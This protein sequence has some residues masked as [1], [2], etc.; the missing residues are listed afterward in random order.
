MKFKLVKLLAFSLVLI[1]GISLFAGCVPIQQT[2]TPTTTAPL[3]TEPEGPAEITVFLRERWAGVPFDGEIIK[4]VQEKTNTKWHI[5]VG[6][7]LDAQ[8][9]TLF[10]AR[11]Y[12]DIITFGGEELYLQSLIKDGILLPLDEHLDK[13]PNLYEKK[14]GIW[15]KLKAGD[16]KVYHVP[17][18][19]EANGGVDVLMSYRKDWLDKF[20]FEIPETIEEYITVADAFSNQD[21]DG[22]NI[23]DTFAIGARQGSLGRFGDFIFAAHGVLPYFWIEEDDGSLVYGSVHPNMREALKVAA[24]LFEIGAID[25]EFIT[26]SSSTYNA[27]LTS[28]VYGACAIFRT[29]FDPTNATLYIPFKEKVPNGEWVF[30][31]IPK[32]A[33]YREDINLRATSPRGW[34]R[35]GI[36]AKSKEVDACLRVL[37]WMN[38]DEGIMYSQYGVEG[39]HYEFKDGVVKKLVDEETSRAL[40]IYEL[41]IG[42]EVLPLDYTPE[43][44]AST[45]FCKSR[46]SFSAADGLIVEEATLYELD[47]EEY[48]NSQIIRIIF[49]EVPVDEG[50]D[51]MVSEFYRRGGQELTDAYNRAKKAK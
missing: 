20:G 50:F 31:D 47:L 11:A 38:T 39:E 33:T 28:G 12:P 3:P 40:G 17:G 7:D 43:L 16:G 1:I 14:K 24:H 30:A 23:K 10:A 25:P 19:T 27:K 18:V 46:A 42:S 2:G 4:G 6:T 15:D 49:G 45:N 8:L 21:P 5:I 37:D 44:Q 26:D 13:L 41:Y 22:N 9:N 36:Y 35:T 32:A 29:N 34:V 51:E 48:T